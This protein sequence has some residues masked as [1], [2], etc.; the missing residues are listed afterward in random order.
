[1]SAERE[2]L[3]IAVTVKCDESMVA[4]LDNLQRER[5][6]E[7]GIPLTRGV[8]IRLLLRAQLGTK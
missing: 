7:L 3:T 2:K 8:L 4:A 5:E 6:L 1:M